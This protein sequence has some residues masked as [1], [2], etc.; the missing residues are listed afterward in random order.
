MNGLTAPDHPARV[1]RLQGALHDRNLPALLLSDLLNIRWATGFT[2]SNARC[3]VQGDQVVLITDSR[4]E[5]QA[6]EQVGRGIEVVIAGTAD[7]DR[8]DDHVGRLLESDRVGFESDHLTV[9][10]H[11][12]LRSRLADAGRDS[13]SWEPT[14]G[15]VA[16]LRRCKDRSEI[17]RLTLA[18]RI[19]DD[20]LAAMGEWLRPGVTERRAARQL[21]WEMA[22]R[23]SERPSFP[24]ILASGP[25][26]AKPHARPSERVLAA[27]DLVVIDFGATV[28]G[29]GSDMTRTL[30][31]GDPSPEQVVWYERV[32]AA[33]SAGVAAVEVGAELRSIDRVTRSALTESGQ[34]GAYLH[35][36]GHGLGLYIHEPPIL[37]PRVDGVVE[38]GMTLTVEPG[39]YLPGVGGVRVEDLVL[40]TTDGPEV[41]TC[42]P[43]GLG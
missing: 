25:N 39:A 10:D 33:Q 12:A 36:T 37:T 9:S 35:G 16:G 34:E 6:A 5:V 27:G 42:A 7:G 43:K 11:E 17:E 31:I 26:G 1:A 20:A 15:I 18:C 4:Y 40:A 30:C 38:A 22:E 28:D 32:W 21:E 24:T 3:L 2:G 29:Y 13:V 41:L 8:S 14:E 23:G 19:A